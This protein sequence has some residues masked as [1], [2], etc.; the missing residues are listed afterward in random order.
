M[1]DRSIQRNT[2]MAIDVRIIRPP[3]VG[4]PRFTKWLCGP[5]SR[6]GCP[7]PCRTRSQ[8]MNFGPISRPR[9][10]S[11]EHTSELQS[12]MRISYA[13]FCL[14]KKNKTTQNTTQTYHKQQHM[15]STST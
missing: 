7:L 9:N 10:R 14:K 11:E 2:E 4:V 1:L 3:M 8:P 12:L 5:S 15:N 13:V 6:I